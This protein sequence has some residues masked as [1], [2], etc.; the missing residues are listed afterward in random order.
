MKILQ[1]HNKYKKVGGEE[2]VVAEEK[3]VLEQNGHVVIQYLKDSSL[4]E[5]YSKVGLIKLMLSQ[6][7]SKVV[8]NELRA[9]IKRERPDICHVH[10]VY[11]LITPSVYRLCQSQGI[12]VVQT[13]HNFKLV[14]TNGLFFRDGQ[15][16][17]ICLNRNLYNSI[18]YKCYRDSYLATAIQADSIQFH[19]KSG[20]W[21]EGIDRYVCLTEFQKSKLVAGGLNQKK[22]C[23]KPNFIQQAKLK[24][25]DGGYFLFVGRLDRGK[26]LDDLIELFK[27]NR[28]SQ[29]VLIGESDDPSLFHNFRNVQHI[30]KKDRS[31]VMYYLSRCKAVIFP[32]KL[33]EGMPMVIIEAFSM[34]KPVIARDIGSASSMIVEGVTGLK[35]N[36]VQGLIYAVNLLEQDASLINRIGENSFR[37]YET[38]YSELKGYESLMNIYSEVIAE[39]QNGIRKV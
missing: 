37:Q 33:Y 11:P 32:S 35:Y 22:I 6:R 14:C 39:K 16:C 3:K 27:V 12:P 5:N 19:R 2:S 38:Y 34:R 1:V 17:E 20:T 31:E 24:I 25:E 30:G 10:N 28:N 8:E 4:I 26:G 13:V 23:I 9:L 36:D 29:F 21:N 7:R 15:T 18:R